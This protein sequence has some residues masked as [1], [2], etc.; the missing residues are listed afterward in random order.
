MLAMTSNVDYLLIDK[1]VPAHLPDVPI[2]SGY[3]L[4][5][6]FNELP[7]YSRQDRQ[8][9]SQEINQFYPTKDDKFHYTRIDPRIEEKITRNSAILEASER[10]GDMI[11]VRS[12]D[13]LPADP[14]NL[15][16]NDNDKEQ[17]IF[18]LKNEVGRMKDAG[19]PDAYIADYIQKSLSQ[20]YM[21]PVDEASQVQATDENGQVV[22]NSTANMLLN[23]NPIATPQVL[24]QPSVSAA[25]VTPAP[26]TPQSVG[27]ITRQ[28]DAMLNSPVP[29]VLP[30][31]NA[32]SNE[33]KMTERKANVL[34]P[35]ALAQQRRYNSIVDELKQVLTTPR[36][37]GQ[38]ASYGTTGTTQRREP[39]GVYRQ[40][41]IN[42]VYGA[43]ERKT[44]DRAISAQ[45]YEGAGTTRQGTVRPPVRGRGT[46]ARGRGRVIPSREPVQQ[47]RWRG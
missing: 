1:G 33:Q 31:S 16:I 21:K 47:Q 26:A 43:S 7:R 19:M 35:N 32:G 2:P 11:D 28:I 27:R 22:N 12:H 15:D 20:M 5:Y 9:S 25:A 14:T 10:V 36:R 39:E 3:H 40:T 23:P 13:I 46:P 41:R 17:L 34:D 6:M 42:N 8:V 24:A 38:P 4:N 30:R 44:A 29:F 37:S 45:S 18:N